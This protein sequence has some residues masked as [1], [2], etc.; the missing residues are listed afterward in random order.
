MPENE[1]VGIETDYQQR[2]QTA[3]ARIDKERIADAPEDQISSWAKALASEFHENWRNTRKTPTGYEPRPKL[4][5]D[6]NWVNNAREQLIPEYK[7]D[8]ATCKDIVD[9]ANLSFGSLPE[10]WQEENLKAAEFAVHYVVEAIRNNTDNDSLLDNG[11]KAVNYKWI[12]RHNHEPWVQ[13]D[14]ALSEGWSHPD[15]SSKQKEKDKEQVVLAAE[16]IAK[17][18]S[19]NQS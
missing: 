18:F 8:P 16:L 4:T 15:F 5:K 10:D 3:L 13:A 6:Y 11:G 9:I 12:E 17:L 14:P 1:E 19:Q 2:L 7:H